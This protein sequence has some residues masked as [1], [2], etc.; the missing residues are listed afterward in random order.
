MSIDISLKLFAAFAFSTVRPSVSSSFLLLHLSNGMMGKGRQRP[1]D[2][3]G[4]THGHAADV[5]GIAALARTP[6]QRNAA[7]RAK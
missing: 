4:Q 3:I 1:A 2:R 6:D 5:D 7:L